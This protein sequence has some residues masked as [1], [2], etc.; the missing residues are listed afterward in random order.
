MKTH[1]INELMTAPAQ[2]E[3]SEL[4]RLA[5]RCIDAGQLESACWRVA[6][7]SKLLRRRLKRLGCV[8]VHGLDEPTGRGALLG[9]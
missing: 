7:A 4:L 1:P 9:G 3:L 5:T 6:D 2:D 8:D